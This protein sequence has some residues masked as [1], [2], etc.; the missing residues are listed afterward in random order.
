MKLLQII[1]NVIITIMPI[2]VDFFMT[3][4]N[5]FFVSLLCV[6]FFVFS[7][8]IMQIPIKT[9]IAN[10]IVGPRVRIFWVVI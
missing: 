8:S 4:L 2:M 1:A 7:K 6:G 9:T 10:V 3:F 5:R